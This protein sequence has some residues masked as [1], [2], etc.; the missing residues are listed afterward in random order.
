MSKY[1]KS[2]KNQLI[3]FLAKDNYTLKFIRE[4]TNVGELLFFGGSIRD[5]CFFRETP[6]MPR[7]FDIA[8]KFKNKDYF[9]QIINDY[10]YKINRFGGY[11]FKISNIEFD[12]WDL[13]N[14]WAF[15]NTDLSPSEENLAKSVY[16][17]IDGIVYNFNKERLYDEIFRDSLSNRSLDIALEKNPQVELNLLRA[18]IFKEKYNLSFS[19]KLKSVFKNYINHNSDCL[20]ENLYQLQY[21]HYQKIYFSKEKIEKEL[22][23]IYALDI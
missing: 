18:L 3:Y 20:I 8:I 2:I 23:Y 4:L 21:S 6:P 10:K 22:Q 16:L 13:E 7:D 12:V 1:D 14:T 5:I 11:K 19:E 9:N 17:T 15:K